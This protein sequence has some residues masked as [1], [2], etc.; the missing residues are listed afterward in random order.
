MRNQAQRAY[1]LLTSQ[2]ATSWLGDE[3]WAEYLRVRAQAGRTT[4]LAVFGLFLGGATIGFLV[5]MYGSFE[6]LGGVLGR[7]WYWIFLGAPLP[8]VVTTV[9]IIVAAVQVRNLYIRYR[10]CRFLDGYPDDPMAAAARS[11]ISTK[12]VEVLFRAFTIVVPVVLVLTG[13]AWAAAIWLG[14]SSALDC[15]KT[16]KCI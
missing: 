10:L 5:A 11:L 2:P 15:A 8:L 9:V 7:Y 12:P 6:Y 13:F 1:Q 14:T 3:L 16:S 4:T